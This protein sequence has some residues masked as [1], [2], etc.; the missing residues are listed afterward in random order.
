MQGQFVNEF[1]GE[2]AAE[3]DFAGED[4]VQGGTQFDKG[5]AFEEIADST[6]FK[7]VPEVLLVVMP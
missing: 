1:G 3:I 6:G 7:G 4:A 5:G 2:S